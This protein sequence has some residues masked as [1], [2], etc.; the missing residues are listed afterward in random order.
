[1][2][3]PEPLTRTTL[4]DFPLPSESDGDKDEHGRLLIVAGNRQ[5][6]GAA[7]LSARAALRSGVGKLQIATVASVAPAMALH[8]VEA[9]I[10]RVHERLWGDSKRRMERLEA[11]RTHLSPGNP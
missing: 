10:V 1:M 4:R 2:S 6:P 11:F 3:D 7:L 9:L 8:M 5:V